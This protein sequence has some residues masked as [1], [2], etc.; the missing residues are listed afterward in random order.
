MTERRMT[1][2]MSECQSLREILVEAECACKRAGNLGDFQ[3][4]RQSCPVVIAFVI[5]KDL[6][7]MRQTPER[8]RMYD[9]IT[10]PPESVAGRT[11]YLGMESTPAS[12]WIGRINRPFMPDF[13][14]HRILVVGA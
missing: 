14:S 10:V 3:S 9:P 12:R 11:C 6:R 7:L 13:D 2:I 5:D 4:V 8:R 1:E